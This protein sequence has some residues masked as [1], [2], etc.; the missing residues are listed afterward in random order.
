MGL[1][2]LKEQN[3]LLPEQRWGKHSLDTTVPK[4]WLLLVF[5]AALASLAATYL[6]D[7]G[8]PT[9]IGVGGFLVS[10]YAA[11]IL[12]DRAIESQRQRMKGR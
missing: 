6:G 9:W 3:V 8:T 11:T 2:D 4:G 7:G 10:I 1:E 5:A 12:C